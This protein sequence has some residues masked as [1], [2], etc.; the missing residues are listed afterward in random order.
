M[1][2]A[3]A[4]LDFASVDR[5]VVSFSELPVRSLLLHAGGEY[6]RAAPPSWISALLA[7]DEKA[8]G[9]LLQTLAALADADLNIQKAGRRLEVHPNTIYARLLRIRDATG[10]DGQRHHDLVELLLAA[11]CARI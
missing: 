2:E 1:R 4:A 10:L 5:R 9:A 6:V 8:G 7:A 11:E 3:T